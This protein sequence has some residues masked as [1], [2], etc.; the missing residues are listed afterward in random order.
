MS[1]S[2]RADEFIRLLEEHQVRLRAFALSLV[3][4]EADADDVVQTAIVTLWK[5]FDEF[6]PGT[7]FAAW[8]GRVV[9]LKA[10]QQRRRQGRDKLRF[11]DAY[12]DAM[13]RVTIEKDDFSSEMGERERV[14]AAC[15]ARLNAEHREMLRVRYVEGASGERLGAMFNRSG[16]AMRNVLKRIRRSLSDCVSRR[17]QQRDSR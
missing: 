10:Q 5:K 6:E 2:D 1:K 13:A 9:Y 16:V 3:L 8:A 11:G 17:V 14:L 4:N 7:S 12:I 15:V